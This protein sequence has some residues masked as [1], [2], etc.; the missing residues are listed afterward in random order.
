MGLA[1]AWRP[2]KMNDFGAVDEDVP[3]E[4]NVISNCRQIHDSGRGRLSS[5]DYR[6][7]TKM[8]K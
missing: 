5:A 8:M 2:E 7:Y 6:M 1:G 3:I 4:G